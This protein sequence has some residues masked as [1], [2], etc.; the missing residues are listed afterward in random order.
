MSALSSPEITDPYSLRA[1][2]LCPRNCGTDRR[3]R[4]G[5]CR[6]SDT[7]HAARAAKLFYEE[8]PLVG[9]GGSGAI[10][11]TGCNLACPF[12]QNREISR[13]SGGNEGIP[14]SPERLAEICLK[15][16]EV[17]AV[18]INL[19]TASHFV[20]PVAEAITRAKKQGLSIP[21]VYNTSSYE[22]PET[23][24]LL[25]G[26]VDIYLPDLKFCDPELSRRYLGLS[27]YFEKAC[28]AI[29]EMVRQ[30]PV[31]LF[32]DG[33]STLEDTEEVPLMKK[34]V[35]IRHLCM[36][37]Q[38]KD[39]R[40][41]LSWIYHTFGDSVFVSIMNQYTPMGGDVSS[42][43]LLA[44]K[45]QENEYGE[46]VDFAISLGI[47]NGFIQEGDTVSKSFIPAFDGT[48]LL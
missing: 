43:P 37:G 8:G 3:V 17:G 6:S 40:A 19:V 14:L 2:R 18:N 4:Q 22:K 27:D 34:G 10:F 29:A 25:E 13:G 16:Q 7:M 23:L 48:G 26:L 24:A 20:P 42:D 44:R 46:V 45:L 41:V 39:S 5:F 1:C 33:S 36:P 15:L 32:S 35:I 21:V 11:F 9:T 30:C 12:C 38:T 31:P 28:L 47:E